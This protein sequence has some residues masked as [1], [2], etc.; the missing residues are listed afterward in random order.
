VPIDYRIDEERRLVL[1]RVRGDVTEADLF[2]Y[3]REV[4]SRPEV[5]GFNELVDMS[6]VGR[7]VAPSIDRVLELS[8]VSAAMDA[9]QE[10]SRFAIVAPDDLAFGLGRMYQA[11]R[12]LDQR[13]T[14]RVGVFRT[15]D[16]ALAFLGLE[17]NFDPWQLHVAG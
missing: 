10:K 2:T 9:A 6:G 16:Q 5:A 7:I 11:Y 15:L 4:W 14:K 1:A 13:S 17:A 12:G 3:Q 8:S